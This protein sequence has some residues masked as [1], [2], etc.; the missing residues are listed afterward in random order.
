MYTNIYLFF[1]RIFNIY[2][3]M[4]MLGL[5]CYTRAFSSCGELGLL[6][7]AVHGFL[8]V[9]A[10]LVAECGLYRVI[11]LSSCDSQALESESVGFSSC[12]AQ[13]LLL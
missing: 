10:F 9:V 3:L 2:L 11:G 7:T 1:F 5:H 6:F 4:A 8:I 13:A 12:G